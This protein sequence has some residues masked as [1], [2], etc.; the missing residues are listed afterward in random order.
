M[1]Y[2]KIHEL[3]DFSHGLIGHNVQ[4]LIFNSLH[5]LNVK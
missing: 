5:L 1:N 3:C 2:T 4:F